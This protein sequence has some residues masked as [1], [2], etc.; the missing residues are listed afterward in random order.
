M[1]LDVSPAGTP[2]GDQVV[3]RQGA[4]SERQ[5]CQQPC[6]PPDMGLQRRRAFE[7]EQRRV[8]QHRHRIHHRQTQRREP[9]GEAERQQ[10][11]AELQDSR[12]KLDEVTPATNRPTASHHRFG[13]SAIS[14]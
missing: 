1:L 5:Q 14:T 6:T 2:G 11:D 4:R 3:C 8:G 13:A 7:A 9:A 12:A 10:L